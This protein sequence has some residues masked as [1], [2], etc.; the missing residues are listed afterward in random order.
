MDVHPI[1]NG[2]N[3]Y[4]S[5]PMWRQLVWKV[6]SRWQSSQKKLSRRP[7]PDSCSLKIC[8]I[9]DCFPHFIVAKGK[10]LWEYAGWK[11]CGCGTRCWSILWPGNFERFLGSWKPMSGAILCFFSCMHPISWT[12]RGRWLQSTWS[13]KSP[14]NPMKFSF[15]YGSKPWYL[16]N[17]KIAGRWMFI[18][19]N[20]WQYV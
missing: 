9:T 14:L 7:W 4:W 5:I 8:A 13:Q 19:L 11:G 20:R 3:R 2:M 6:F 16:V 1:K 12:S 18:P 17:T 15:G 10:S